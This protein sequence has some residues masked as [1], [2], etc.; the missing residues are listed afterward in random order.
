MGRLQDKVAIITGATS[1]IGQA[2]AG[3]FA[4]EGAKVV[5]ASRR[6]DVGQELAEEIRAKGG[7]AVF[8]AADVAKIA[9]HR[10]LVDT[11]VSTWGRLDIAFNNAGMVEET[12]EI[13]DMSEEIW[14]RTIDVNLTGVFLAMKVQIP[15]L[16]AAGGGSI[17]NTSSVGGLIGSPWIPAYSAAKHGVIGLSKSAALALAARNIRV[18]ALCPG[19]THSDMFDHIIEDPEIHRAMV[20]NH[21]IGRF[22]D[23]IEQARVALFLAS[24][25]SSYMT[26]TVAVVDGGLT[27]R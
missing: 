3:L 14:A 4:E 17:I 8:V 13:Q 27:A 19:G 25:D 15:A 1:G 16:L 23:P 12:V 18:N 24:D 5:L 20:E 10:K 9:D 7:E 2:A 11:A 6:V 26:G 21:P 22:A